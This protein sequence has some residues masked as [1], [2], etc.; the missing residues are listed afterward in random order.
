LIEQL[1]LETI[2]GVH[3]WEKQTAR[4]LLLDLDLGLDVSAA[5]SSDHLRD[6]VNYKAVC[7]SVAALVKEQRYQL[8]E[9]LAEAI[10]RRLFQTYPILTL[11]LKLSKPG[12]VPRTRNIA[13][14]IERRRE[15]YAVCGR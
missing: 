10:A 5:A 2:I 1:E 12:A 9:A 6:A 15:D 7:D 14:R 13:L 8:L 11:G 4:P 3:A